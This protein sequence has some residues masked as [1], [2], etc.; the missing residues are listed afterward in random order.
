MGSF[1]LL[2]LFLAATG[3]YGLLAYTVSRRTHE[4][5]IRMALGARPGEVLTSTIWQGVGLVGAGLVLGTAAALAGGR[6]LSK[7]LFGVHSSDPLTYA[8]VAIVFALVA[9]LA[10]AVPARRAAG[11]D[12]V[13]A[14]RYE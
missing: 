12:P 1:A 2:G 9:V 8:G 3:I 14:L 7:Y 4:I 5:G 10:T 13:I 6:I 11:I